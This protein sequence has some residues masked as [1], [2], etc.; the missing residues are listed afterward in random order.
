MS[1]MSVERRMQSGVALY[2][3]AAT[4]EIG[5]DW[6]PGKQQKLKIF[7]KNHCIFK[8]VEMYLGIIETRR[9][10]LFDK[11]LMF[12]SIVNEKQ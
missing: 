9:S 11:N 10:D 1:G 5:E 3:L 6:A 7:E 2:S 4:A 12:K 8:K